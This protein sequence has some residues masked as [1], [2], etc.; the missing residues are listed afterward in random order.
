MKSAF[1]CPYI[2]D[3]R[4]AVDYARAYSEDELL[5]N[6]NNLASELQQSVLV[7]ATS[8]VCRSH[9]RRYWLALRIKRTPVK[10]FS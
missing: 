5:A 3:A 1:Y 9:L 10:Q 6:L 2:E 7:G 4:L 8:R